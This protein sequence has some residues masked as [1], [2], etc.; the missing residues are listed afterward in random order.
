MAV[1]GLVFSLTGSPSWAVLGG[2]AS[3]ARGFT[4]QIIA[5]NA[6]ETFAMVA[7]AVALGWL[8]LG[9]TDWK[10]R[11]AVL[12]GVGSAAAILSNGKVFQLYAVTLILAGLWWLAAHPGRRRPV[13]VWL[14]TA[15]LACAVPVLPWAWR[16]LAGLGLIG[17]GQHPIV[18]PWRDVTRWNEPLL[19][20]LALAGAVIAVIRGPRLARVLAGHGL[21]CLA[22]AQYWVLLRLWSPPWFEIVKIPFDEWLGTDRLFV[23]PFPYPYTNEVGFIGYTIALPVLAAYLG[24]VASGWAGRLG[25]WARVACLVVGALL[26]LAA[27]RS[28]LPGEPLGYQLLTT[29]DYH[30]LKWVARST[31]RATTLLLN[32]WH[33]SPAPEGNWAAVVADRPTVF[34]RADDSFIRWL[35]PPLGGEAMK[36][37]YQ[38]PGAPTSLPLLRASGVTHVFVPARL[39]PALTDAYERARGFEKVVEASAPGGQRAA[40]FAV[41]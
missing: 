30:A 3:L 22:I 1:A 13:F 33:M 8:A 31:P 27:T 11:T 6:T 17:L 21:A 18:H 15:T 9:V 28:M 36:A 14:A 5:S 7:M 23:T 39:S 24:H 19:L 37:A 20:A 32:P 41:K 2:M 38:G 40:I 16:A 4:F 12:V 29:A 10:W 25:R 34:F 26:A 35:G